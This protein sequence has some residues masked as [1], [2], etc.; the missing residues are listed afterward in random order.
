MNNTRKSKK[1]AFSIFQTALRFS[2]SSRGGFLLVVFIE[3]LIFFYLTI[4]HRLVAGHDGFQLFTMMYV[5]LNDAF[6][7]SGIPQWSPF[8]MHG[9]IVIFTY[10]LGGG[11]LEKVLF[12]CGHFLPSLDVLS[13][14][15]SSLFVNQFVLLTGAWLLGSQFYSS[16][17]TVFF[18]SLSITG[19][20]IWMLQPSYNF[21]FYYAIPLILYFLHIFLKSG[22]LRY[23]FLAGNLFLL[24]AFCNLPHFLIVQS[25]CIVIYIL[26][27]IIFNDI[28]IFVIIK[29]NKYRA[30]F[31]INIFNLLLLLFAL[32]FFLRFGSDQLT[33]Y[34]SRNPD[35][36]VT[37][38]T[39]LHYGGNFKWKIWLELLLGVS[40]CADYTLY[41]GMLGFPLVVAGI[42]LNVSRRNVHF[43]LTTIVLLLF[44][45]GTVVSV[46]FY[47]CWPLMKYYR[48]LI[49]LSPLIKVLFCFLAGFGFDGLLISFSQINNN[50]KNKIFVIC[51]TV[52]L[53][54]LFAA[55]LFLARNPAYSRALVK[56]MVPQFL[57][58]FLPLLRDDLL[59]LL[60][61]RTAVFSLIALVLIFSFCFFQK[62]KKY[63][64][65]AIG[66]LVF[67]GI[68]MYT[69]KCF[70]IYT[71]TVPLTDSSYEI[72]RLQPVPYA[73][74]RDL[75]F[76]NDNP[77][78]ELLKEL[79]RVADSGSF[80]ASVNAFLFKDQLGNSF[81]T[82]FWMRPLD[83]Y[84]KAYW[85]QS[86]D[87][88]SIP[89]RGLYYRSGDEYPRLEFPKD[90]P[91]ALKISGVTEDKI[92]FFSDAEIITSEKEIASRI[93]HPAYRGDVLFLSPLQDGSRRTDS[94]TRISAN[95]LSSTNRL[96]LSYQV[97]DFDSNNLKLAA[98]VNNRDSVWLLYSDV[99]HPLWKA[100]V[101]GR[102]V[103]VY[104]A[105]LAYKAIPLEKGY[106]DVHFSF[107]SKWASFFHYFVGLHSLLWLIM[108][109]SL[110][111]KIL[112]GDS[113]SVLTGRLQE[114]G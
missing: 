87:D 9:T 101:N 70:E 1:P 51:L 77:R 92:Q 110:A 46:F 27:F 29:N 62:E 21:Y 11:F 60:L 59:S 14:F 3:A 50:R 19:S 107:G 112:R 76:W 31:F 5:F 106:N 22:R 49:L 78:A 86:I 113:G 79:P 100:T 56:S 105:N 8:V 66:L 12:I 68:D 63:I 58:L 39:F 34:S 10:F 15:Y 64:L 52:F 30:K 24:Q 45:M 47:Y 103:P 73:R 55:T 90:H 6:N 26:I 32:F 96:R 2:V 72:T 7:H 91:A 17:W 41:T 54:V 99:W 43:W 71:K 16:R 4:D 20:S 109:F 95:E 74:R 81:R 93:T 40:P 42:M 108:I 89:P 75:S 69:F 102:M 97:K 61:Q 13:V 37:L 82:D 44:S 38:D 111:A 85:G 28:N 94:S 18:V 98:Q 114:T 67:H 104:R 83:K 80:Y 84:M 65:I 88:V 53:A 25:L 48:H 33:I 57:P 36:A 23:L 35:G